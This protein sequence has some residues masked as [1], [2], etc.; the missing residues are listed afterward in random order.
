MRIGNCTWTS[1][2]FA[3][4]F[5]TASILTTTAW[6]D[7]I[8]K[9][10]VKLHVTKRGPDY[11]RPWTKSAPTPSVGS[12]SIIE[13]NRILTNAHVVQ[14]ATQILVQPDQ[15]TDRYPAKL[16]G[17]APGLDL[18]LLEV[19]DKTFAKGRKPLEFDAT[20]P[21]IKDS[22]NVYGYPMGG[23][24]LSITQGIVSRIEYQASAH[25]DSLLMIQVDAALNPGNSGGPAIIDGKIAGVV[26]SK[27]EQADNIGYVIATEEVLRF[28][29]DIKDGKYDGK[30]DIPFGSPLQYTENR[31][32]RKRLK[33]PEGM[34]GLMINEPVYVRPELPVKTWDVITHIGDY[35]IDKQGMIS[36]RDD[37]KL[38]CTYVI[39]KL[40]KDGKV[41]LTIWRDGKSM[42]VEIPT[43]TKNFQVLQPL[44]NHYPRYY[45]HGPL[46]LMQADQDIAQILLQKMGPTLLII[47]SPWALRLGDSKTFPEEELVM[48]GL[49]FYPHAMSQG[50]ESMMPFSIVSH[51]NDTKVKNLRHAVKLLKHAKGEFLT[52]QLAGYNTKVVFPREEAAKLTEE[53][54]EAEGIR[55]QCSPDLRDV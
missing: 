30:P 5:V 36:I 11:S 24:Q 53:I 20:I 26:C 13:G 12:G 44:G 18:A 1:L 8:S 31:V 14:F 41:P 43:T 33:I 32:L 22:L 27:I 28:L 35:P 50:Y 16:I 19:T 25:S 37:L 54:L 40:V 10:V 55:N 7:N 45:M 4:S 39:P 23:E 51:I 38:N 47:R 21:H 9:S 17:I 52:L 48:I 46:V 6:A 49:R 29:E 15:S 3:I 42:K 2:V 34:G